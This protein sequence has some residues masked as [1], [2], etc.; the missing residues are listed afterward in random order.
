MKRAI[1]RS[2]DP[3][4]NN[5][6]G[7]YGSG[8]FSNYVRCIQQLMEVEGNSSF[9]G[10][11]PYIDWTKS[12]FTENNGI[13]EDRPNF[14]GASNPWDSWFEQLPLDVSD[15]LVHCNTSYI[16]EILDH[17]NFY[18]NQDMLDHVRFLD[19]KYIKLHSHLR[20]AIDAIWEKEFKDNYVLGVIA[21]GAE[22]RFYHNEQGFATVEFYIS[23]IEKILQQNPQINKIFLV[24]DLIDW[25][26][27]IKNRFPN[28]FF[29]PNVNRIREN[30]DPDFFYW[31]IYWWS[32]PNRPNHGI[33]LGEESL[34]QTHLLA[35]SNILFG[36]QSGFVNGAMIFTKGYDHTYIYDGLSPFYIT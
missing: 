15:E 18:L 34:I 20:I 29:L 24:C 1:V 10:A 2:D 13:L 26:E 28:V 19:S 11:L 36:L 17:K 21:R 8:F 16:P 7:L 14:E 3:K 12:W 35:R 23:N 30:P 33:L 5:K 22:R 31:N 6:W 9:Q 25:V 32:Y 27:E 4:A